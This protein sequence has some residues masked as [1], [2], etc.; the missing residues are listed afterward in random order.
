MPD[1]LRVVIGTA[2]NPEN[3]ELL[4][5]LEPR[6]DVV[7]EPSLLGEA[8]VNWMTRHTRSADDESRFQELVDTAEALFGVPDHSGRSLARTVAANPGLRWVHT[9]PAGGGQQVKSAQLPQEALDRIV[10]TTSAG[11]HAGPLA[12][13]AVFGVLA[14]AKRL[15]YLR[16]AQIRHH[17]AERVAMNQLV[18]MTVAVVGLGHIGMA[19]AS[20]LSA[21]GCRVVGIHRHE[22]DAPGVSQIFPVERFAEVAGEVDAIVLAL[23]GTEQT[24]KMLSREVLAGV[25]RGATVVNVGRG[26]TVDEPALVEAVEDGRVGFAALDVTYS[27]PLAA[28]SPLWDLPNV[29]ISPHTAA[30]SD[31]EPRLITELFARNATAYLD[32]RP[33][34]NVVNTV[35]F[36]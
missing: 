1:R 21:L 18:D 16:T 31:H 4:R 6:L 30:I 24:E 35:E 12:E 11:V 19:T 15:G 34:E 29:L 8:S 14:G 20:K 23:P 2:Q 9:I 7:F 36:Y 10:F 13:F 26:T 27:E 5:R 28:D 25:R 17:W 33:L 22:V 32:G 3:V